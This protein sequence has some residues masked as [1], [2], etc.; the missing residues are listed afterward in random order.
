MAPTRLQYC[1]IKFQVLGRPVH[2]I[3]LCCAC[4]QMK[5]LSIWCFFELWKWKYYHMVG[6]NLIVFFC[7]YNSCF[8]FDK[9]S[10]TTGW[11]GDTN[12]EK[13]PVCFT[14]S[15]R[16]YRPST[17]SLPHQNFTSFFTVHLHIHSSFPQKFCFS[18][19]KKHHI[20]S[21]SHFKPT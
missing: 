5:L 15:C 16:C 7:I 12:H 19:D 20:L 13:P 10:N 8:S 4:W 11:N 14:D 18:C 21:S 6:Q 9:I 3:E 2:D 1:S 17:E